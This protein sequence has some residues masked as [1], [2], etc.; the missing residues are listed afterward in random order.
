MFT[1][2]YHTLDTSLTFQLIRSLSLATTVADNPTH[3]PPFFPF[4]SQNPHP[5]SPPPPASPPSAPPPTPSPS[6]SP[7]PPP[8]RFTIISSSWCACASV[9]SPCWCCWRDASCPCSRRRQRRGSWFRLRTGWRRLG[10]RFWRRWRWG[11]WGWCFD[12]F[13]LVCW[14]FFFFLGG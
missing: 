9:C 10:G 2:R 4:F 8:P 5:C 11:R 3:H 12:G 13:I 7:P 14:F 6:S 1:K